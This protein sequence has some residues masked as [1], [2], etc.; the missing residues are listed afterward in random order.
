MTCAGQVM[1]TWSPGVPTSGSL[2][3][4]LQHLSPLS[5]THSQLT[6][7]FSLSQF[8]VIQ[9]GQE[10]CRDTQHP[11]KVTLA[12]CTCSRITSPHSWKRPSDG[13]HPQFLSFFPSFQAPAQHNSPHPLHAHP[14]AFKNFSVFLLTSAPHPCLPVF[15]SL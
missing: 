11:P 13:K 3:T 6:R 12:S 14:P 1:A 5:Y 2:E 4:L 10:I 9:V 8:E 15:L 7:F